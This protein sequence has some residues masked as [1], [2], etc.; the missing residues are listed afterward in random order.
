MADEVSRGNASRRI[1]EDTAFT[2][3]VSEYSRQITLQWSQAKTVAVR[4]ELHA[5]QLALTN[6]VNNLSG[7]MQSADYILKKDN[8]DGFFK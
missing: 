4:E 7:Y 6:V 2:D 5:Q 8:K 3:A 1:L